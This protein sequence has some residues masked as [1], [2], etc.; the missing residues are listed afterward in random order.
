MRIGGWE[1]SLNRANNTIK[2]VENKINKVLFQFGLMEV[3]NDY[4]ATWAIEVA[5]K[6]NPDVY[7]I[8]QQMSGKTATIPSYIKRLKEKE[9]YNKF[10]QY[11]GY[12]HKN[13]THLLL[14]TKA[15]SKAFD[16]EYL[17]NP[18]ERPN[19]L[20]TWNEFTQLF[21]TYLR[22]TGNVFIYTLRNE[23]KQPIA[24]YLMPSHKM[25]I[26]IK[27]D[28]MN[29]TM[30]SPILGYCLDDTT[31]TIPFA[32]DEIHHIKYPNP[33]WT[34]DAEQLIGHSPLK[35]AYVN[36]EN[37]IEANAHIQRLFKSA[38]AIGVAY[39]EDGSNWGNEQAKQFS[40]AIK[41][42][43]GS[44]ER[45]AR[46]KAVSGKVGFTRM[47]LGNDEMDTWTA[48][49]WDRKTLCNVLGW[50]DELLNND[51]KA[52]LSSNEIEFARKI[53]IQDNI[54]PDLQLLE[55]YFNQ[56]YLPF[57]KGYENTK[58]FY[59]VSELPEMQDD[60]K[61]LMEWA[62]K[63]PITPNEIRDLIK[64]EPLKNEGMD[65]I[66]VSRQKI[67]MDE[68]MITDDFFTPIDDE[69]KPKI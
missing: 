26:L 1:L 22:L 29:L 61:T 3:K 2:E 63:A 34:I 65:D 4:T 27:S 10:L 60:I 17:K 7:A 31:Y 67:R 54:L 68:A 36:V 53:V 12:Q 47:S 58:L 57:F 37:Q 45:M 18:L 39:A 5:Y 46:I 41:E 11:R 52:S 64:F 23:Q 6:N 44:G 30:E 42:M 25:K 35:A 56:K 49:L 20:Q 59:D 43:D 9:S 66:W 21:K 28:A 24:V 13:N 8:I 50:Q 51:G 33:E 69:A 16:E 48:L 15:K 14:E 55:E 40:D 38:G 32:E 19:I 62:D